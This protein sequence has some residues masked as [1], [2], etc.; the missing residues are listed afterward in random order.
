LGA[1]RGPIGQIGRGPALSPLAWPIG[2]GAP[3][4]KIKNKILKNK[5]LKNKILKRDVLF[6]PPHKTT[7]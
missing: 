6:L 2:R 1:R 3:P 4:E 5:I 7:L